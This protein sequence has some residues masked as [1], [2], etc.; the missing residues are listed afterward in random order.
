MVLFVLLRLSMFF[1]FFA[2]AFVLE[3]FSAQRPNPR[4][5]SRSN[6]GRGHVT[7]KVYTRPRLD[8]VCLS[9]Q[10]YNDYKHSPPVPTSRRVLGESDQCASATCQGCHFQ[11]TQGHVDISNWH[12]SPCAHHQIVEHVCVGFIGDIVVSAGMYHLDQR[13]QVDHP[14]LG[15]TKLSQ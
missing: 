12:H 7:Q 13:F 4:C 10:D 5:M 6:L 1:L 8:P 11:R 14:K 9:E 3:D 15:E 2:F